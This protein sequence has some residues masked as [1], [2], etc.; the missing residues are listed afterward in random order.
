MRRSIL[1]ICLLLVFPA[2]ADAHGGFT[3]PKPKGTFERVTDQIAKAMDAVEPTTE[4]PPTLA[5]I[6]E[7]ESGGDY[8]EVNPSSGAAG[9]WQFLD[10]TW[11]S[12]GGSGSAADAS[13]E[14][15]DRRALM[16]WDGGAGASHWAASASCWGG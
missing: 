1:V 6:R 13:P 8:T 9:A 4:I 3:P 7:C 14:E 5:R 16:L 12:V 2:S 10:S 15:Q 11:A